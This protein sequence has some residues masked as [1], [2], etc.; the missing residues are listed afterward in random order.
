[1]KAV[2]IASENDEYQVIR[3]LKESRS[4]RAKLGEVFI[5]GTESIK[6]AAAAGLDITRAIFDSARE[7]SGWARAFLS[8]LPE[9]GRIA[10]EASLYRSLCD[11]EEPSELLVTARAGPGTIAG[12][13]LPP[14]PFVL[15]LDRPSDC[16]N[17]GLI[18][19]SANSFGVDAVLV[20]GHAVDPFDPKAIR[21]SLGAI[22]HCRLAR[23]ESMRELETWIAGQ[24]ERSGLALVGTDSSGEAELSER[25]LRR[26]I[27]LALGN[28]AKGLS[29]ALKE[30]CDFVVRIPMEGQVN[31]LNV[32]CAGSIFMWDVYRAGLD[33]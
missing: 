31:S 20:L 27:A 16:G 11:R 29:V 5:E 3:S 2:S 26:P 32:A 8:D 21:A 19:R 18:V 17:F 10:M 24:R 23:V 15:V 6:Q 33:R 30:L 25:P 12:L 14:E 28:E 13:E 9:T 4:K 7:L 1:M 22:F